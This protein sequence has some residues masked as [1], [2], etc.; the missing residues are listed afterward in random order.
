MLFCPGWGDT[1]RLGVSLGTRRGGRNASGGAGRLAVRA[2]SANAIEE[3]NLVDGNGDDPDPGDTDPPDRADSLEADASDNV[4]GGME[5]SAA[6]GAGGRG[7][8]VDCLSAM[9]RLYA[10]CFCFS[11]LRRL[12]MIFRIVGRYMLRVS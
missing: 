9:R 5:A 10:P 2:R 11:P 7:G 4:G 6:K 12:K 3:G 8:G 1:L